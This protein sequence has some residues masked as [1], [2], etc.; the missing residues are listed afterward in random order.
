M[1][2]VFNIFIFRVLPSGKALDF[3]SNIR[4]FESFYPR[5]L[6][7]NT[8]VKYNIIYLSYKNIIINY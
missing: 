3:D 5:L 1:D 4:R 2:T 7:N 6:Y 8:F